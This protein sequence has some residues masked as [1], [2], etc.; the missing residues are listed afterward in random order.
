EY[1][2]Q[3]ASD[4]D[5]RAGRD[6]HRDGTGEDQ[7]GKQRRR[8]DGG[9][10]RGDGRGGAARRAAELAGGRLFL[11]GALF[12]AFGGLVGQLAFDLIHREVAT[13]GFFGQHQVDVVTA[14]AS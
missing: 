11:P 5:C 6:R 13:A 2:N 10:G 7:A 14:V 4:T 12:G 8:A 1:A 9:E 3:S